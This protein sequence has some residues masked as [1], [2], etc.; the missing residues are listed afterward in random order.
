MKKLLIVTLTVGFACLAVQ[1]Q[2]IARLANR[3]AQMEAASPKWPGTETAQ[4]KWPG[5]NTGTK[6]AAAKA[7]RAAAELDIMVTNGENTKK[8]Q[9]LV[10]QHKQDPLFADLSN[11]FSNFEV[12]TSGK[13]YQDLSTKKPSSLYEAGFVY[14][15]SCIQEDVAK[16]A[17]INQEV[18]RQVV[19]LLRA[20]HYT[21]KH[22]HYVIPKSAGWITWPEAL[23]V[24]HTTLGMHSAG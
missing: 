19:I 13:Y 20:S 18:A 10:N 23:K 9:E 11:I 7:S 17:R 22:D 15:I 4:P 21:Y 8:F 5:S 3:E 14:R 2:G 16:V 1:A 24:R 6:R 12:V